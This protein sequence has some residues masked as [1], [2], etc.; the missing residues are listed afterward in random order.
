MPSAE[1]KRPRDT[2][3]QEGDETLVGDDLV[4]RALLAYLSEPTAAGR[5]AL[6]E[7]ARG[8][9][10]ALAEVEE[11]LAADAELQQLMGSLGPLAANM[12]ASE[13]TAK[14]ALEE[15][16]LAPPVLREPLVLSAEPLE[17]AEVSA[18]PAQ[19]TRASSPPEPER[20]MAMLFAGGA[21]S[22]LS[23]GLAVWLLWPRPEL[24]IPIATKTP[25]ETHRPRRP[26][27]PKGD[28]WVP[29]VVTPGIWHYALG[30]TDP[31][32]R[33]GGPSPDPLVDREKRQPLKRF[34]EPVYAAGL[35]AGSS[36]SLNVAASEGY[37]A[38]VVTTATDNFAIEAWF[39]PATAGA[40]IVVNNGDGGHNGYGLLLH[41]N[42]HPGRVTYMGLFGGIRFLDTNIDVKAGVAAHLAVVRA[43]GQT[44]VY[45]NGKAFPQGAVGPNAPDGIFQIAQSAKF[46]GT[47]DEVRVW[48]F[49]PGGFKPSDLLYGK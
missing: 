23:L 32:A 24:A 9:P 27:V 15:P 13:A 5:S 30:E 17:S 39:K 12:L 36:W 14:T 34:G 11:F 42:G 4:N 31:E 45:L 49:P 43:A 26:F 29:P 21:I 2:E 38:P 40:T 35:A 28:L 19:P 25:V 6:L 10:E 41:D 7:A 37:S 48:V 33:Q 1:N 20:G 3:A 47:V 8:S 46:Q 22:L 16:H 18:L 44:T